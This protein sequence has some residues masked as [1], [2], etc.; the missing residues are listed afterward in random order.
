MGRE[1]APVR[2]WV[3]TPPAVEPFTTDEMRKHLRVHHR[4][5]D[6]KI[7]RLITQARVVAEKLQG[8][9]LIT[10]TLSAAWSRFPTADEHGGRLVLPRPP[11]ASVT[12]ITYIDPDGNAQGWDAAKWQ[13]VTN[14]LG[15]WLCPV[16]DEVYPSTKAGVAE[17]VTVLY[18]AGYGAAATNVPEP[19]RGG[20]EQLVDH[21]FRNRG[22]VASKL[23]EIPMTA[24]TLLELNEVPEV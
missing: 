11:C 22:I 20:I 9:S 17:A 7:G 24:R 6:V 10:Q 13:L 14:D 8:R 4:E 2:Q 18:V 3:V 1:L 21:A 15:A 16:A 12:S 19:T 5:E 23:D